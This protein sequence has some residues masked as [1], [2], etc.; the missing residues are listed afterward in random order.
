MAQRAVELT[1]DSPHIWN[2][3]GVAHYRAGNGAQAIAALEKSMA[4]YAGREESVNTFFLAMAHWQ[5][6]EK[7]KARMWYDRAVAWSE[8]KDPANA[9][10]RQFRAEASQLLGIK[11]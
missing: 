11:K 6:G 3:L 2:T 9:T 5:L 7:D 1:P 8:K 4:L 10:I